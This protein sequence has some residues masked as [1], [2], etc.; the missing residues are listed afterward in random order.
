MGLNKKD[1]PD[2]TEFWVEATDSIQTQK[3]LDEFIEENIASQ[4]AGFKEYFDEYVAK[5]DLTLPEIM[6]K[7]N[8]GKGYFY[9][10][11]NGDRQPKRDKVIALCIG[12]GMDLKHLDRAL[13][14]TKYSKLD[15]KDERDLRIRFAVKQG[16][17]TVLDLN[18][19][20]DDAG[21]DILA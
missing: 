4:Y 17:D 2:N 9:N 12:A 15:P 10:I 13:R 18:L 6:R 14:I 16:I 19:I 7:S 1:L 3:E 8:I 11:I 20:L 21:L 5:N